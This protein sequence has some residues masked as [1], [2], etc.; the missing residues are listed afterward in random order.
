[1]L[2]ITIDPACD[3]GKRLYT[4]CRLVDINGGCDSQDDLPVFIRELPFSAVRQRSK[5][6]ST[7]QFH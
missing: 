6:V 3:C 4:V 5:Y 2:R 1:V 7:L